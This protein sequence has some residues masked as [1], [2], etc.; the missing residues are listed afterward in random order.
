MGPLNTAVDYRRRC[1]QKYTVL[2]RYSICNKTKHQELRSIVPFF[3]YQLFFF[4]IFQAQHIGVY[5]YV[6]FLFKMI[7]HILC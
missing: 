4:T 3:R 5:M 6:L 7:F 1:S 2:N